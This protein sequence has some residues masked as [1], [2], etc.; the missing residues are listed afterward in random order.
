MFWNVA[1]VTV[2]VLAFILLNRDLGG[3]KHRK[4]FDR[5]FL[6]GANTGKHR[7]LEF[8]KISRKVAW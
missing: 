6:S 8:S 2:L 3:P 1:I 4:V 5:K 7:I